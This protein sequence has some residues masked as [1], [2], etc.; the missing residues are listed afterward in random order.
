M[1]RPMSLLRAIL[2]HAILLRRYTSQ[3]L[4]YSRRT[5]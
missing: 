5:Y 2:L 3:P 4:R 1:Q